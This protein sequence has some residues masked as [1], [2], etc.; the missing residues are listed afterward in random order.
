MNIKR[1]L[2]DLIWSHGP[3]LTIY[4]AYCH[5]SISSL[6]FSLESRF[7]TNLVI[8]T[9]MFNRYLKLKSWVPTPNP[10]LSQLSTSQEKNASIYIIMQSKSRFYLWF[11]NFPLQLIKKFSQLYTPKH[12]LDPSTPLHITPLLLPW[13]K[14]QLLK[15]TA[16]TLA[17]PTYHSPYSLKCP[18]LLY[19]E[20]PQVIIKPSRLWPFT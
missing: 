16:F 17:H 14:P 15:A 4:P 7:T 13:S 11:P 2:D 19:L 18:R 3:K 5:V 6:N 8:F 9:W 20:N 12:T 1:L 10:L